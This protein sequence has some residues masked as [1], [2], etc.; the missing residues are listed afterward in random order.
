LTVTVLSWVVPAW[1]EMNY[2]KLNVQESSSEFGSAA[3][4]SVP[5]MQSLSPS[6]VPNCESVIGDTIV[7]PT[8]DVFVTVTV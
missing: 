4:S 5:T 1:P 3:V 8:G 2:S 6:K 7:T